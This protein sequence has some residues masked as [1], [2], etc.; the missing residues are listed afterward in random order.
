M[1]DSGTSESPKIADLKRRLAAE[2]SSRLFIELARE[3][4]ESGQLEAAANVCNRGLKKHPSYLSARVLL[5]RVCFDMGRVEESR[6]AMESVLAQAPDNLVARRVIAEICAEQ[7]DDAGAL[8]RY[9]ALLAFSPGDAD[10]K[11]RIAQL[12]AK[13]AAVVPDP[14]VETPSSVEPSAAREAAPAREPTIGYV[15]PRTVD[16]RELDPAVLAT[17]TLAEIYL[18]QGLKDK[19]ARVYREILKGDPAN[20]E[21]LQRLGEIEPSAPAAPAPDPAEQGRLRKIA[22]LNSWLEVIKGAAPRHVVRGG[23]GRG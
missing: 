22:L 20:A 4:F 9:R 7:G 8:E 3:Y 15:A 2:P 21:A 14:P 1:P 11:K 12:E 5:G 17:P 19:A 18:Q 13:L 23:G 16:D 6:E 10:T